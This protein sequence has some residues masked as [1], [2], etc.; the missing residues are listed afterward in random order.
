[1]DGDERREALERE[2]SH[3]TVRILLVAAA[4]VAASTDA[5]QAATARYQCSGGTRLTANFS[6]PSLKSG[7]VVL[8][9][10]GSPGAI[11]LPQA[12]SAD[13]GRYADN[14][15][16]F[17]IKGTSATLTSGGRSETCQAQ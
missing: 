2:H 15:M 14:R 13:G 12:M 5:S 10:A 4:L 8:R 11:A 16:E 1:M 7:R 3:M 9:I 17:W 6:P